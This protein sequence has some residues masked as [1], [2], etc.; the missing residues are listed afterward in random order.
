MCFHSNRNIPTKCGD[1]LSI[2]ERTALV[3]L[4]TRWRQPCWNLTT[5]RFL[6]AHMYC[7]SKSQH[8]YQ[9]LH[10][11]WLTNARTHQLFK[12]QDGGSRHV[13]CRLTNS[14][15]YH[16]CVVIYC[17]NIPTKCCEIWSINERTASVSKFKMAA[18]AILKSGHQMP[19]DS[20]HVLL[21][22]IATLLP[23]LLKIGRKLRERHQF[24]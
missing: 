19:F 6:I 8:A 12:I 9:K 24:L 7:Y 20:T 3:C 21:F 10:E 2:N 11:N 17:R 22:V 4:N 1:I 14:F 13:G 5:R 23:N 15:R 18:A 16:G